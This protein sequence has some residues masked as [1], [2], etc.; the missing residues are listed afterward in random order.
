MGRIAPRRRKATRFYQPLLRSWL[1]LMPRNSSKPKLASTPDAEPAPPWY[2][3]IKALPAK[4]W[5][6]PDS[7]SWMEPL[8]P[9][10]RRGLIVALA[11][12]LLGLLWPYSPPSPPTLTPVPLQAEPPL[13]AELLNGNTPVAQGTW[14]SYQI[15]PGQTLAQ[16]FRDNNLPINNV[17]AMAAVEG[18]DKPLSSLRAGQQV[19]IQRDVQGMVTVLELTTP[20]NRQILFSRQA[21]GSYRQTR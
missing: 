2:H 7:F 18:D 17:F 8:P 19:R 15:Q 21:D 13:Q 9:P 10:H 20:D 3:R 14:L 6:L 12:L 4:L 16:L 1:T 5:H 11:L